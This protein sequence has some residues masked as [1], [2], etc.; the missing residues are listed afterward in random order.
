MRNL[1]KKKKDNKNSNQSK[2]N[3][4]NKCLICEYYNKDTQS[5]IKNIEIDWNKEKCKEYIIASHL[6]MF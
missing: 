1:F 2:I 4:N 5:C 6:V 3:D